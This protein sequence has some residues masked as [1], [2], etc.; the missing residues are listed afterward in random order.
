VSPSP[1]RNLERFRLL[2]E[3]SRDIIAEVA[4]DG[5]VIYGSPNVTAVLGYP[6][7]GLLRTSVFNLV[8]PEDLAGVKQL[9][10]ASAGSATCRGRH[11]DGTWRWME[12]SSRNFSGLDGEGRKVL[13]ARDITARKNAED[14]RQLMERQLMQAQ[15]QS[16]LG[17][18][19]GGIAHDFNNV[20]TAI[21]GNAELA[22]MTIEPRSAA[23]DNID[24]ILL[25]SQRAQGM[26]ERLAALGR[27]QPVAYRPMALSPTILE[28]VDFLR[29]LLPAGIRIEVSL[30][31]DR[32]ATVADATQVHQALLN[33]LINASQ[34]MPQGAGVIE[35]TLRRFCVPEGSSRTYDDLPAGPYLRLTVRDTGTGMDAETVRR[36]F[37]A[38]FTTKSPG[39][40]TGLGL[41]VVQ[42]VMRNHRGTV[43]VSSY[44]GKGSVFDLFFPQPG[45][46]VPARP[47]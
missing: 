16:L 21:I 34:A 6:L 8:H 31:D 41:T 10:E 5:T 43:L 22:R 15:K 26:V 9:F 28:V 40:G 47:E 42:Q 45:P 35:I 17:T 23:L 24:R 19:T 12:V 38:Y 33:L 30:N 46:E 44:V 18:L 4:L 1:D 13:I 37:D 25:A 39:Q 32:G 20:M 36:M 29:P 2:V 3:N 27:G 14:A 7:E 11:Q